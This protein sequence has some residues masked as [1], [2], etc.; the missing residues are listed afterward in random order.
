LAENIN[1]QKR[2]MELR[3]QQQREK[4]LAINER[5]GMDVMHWMN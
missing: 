4:M 2:A 5:I 3:Q 1:E